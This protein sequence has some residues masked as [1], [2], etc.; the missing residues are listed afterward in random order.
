MGTGDVELIIQKHGFSR[1]MQ[2]TL[3][4][5]RFRISTIRTR[6]CYSLTSNNKSIGII[7]IRGNKMYSP[8][9]F[10][11]KIVTLMTLFVSVFIASRI[12]IQKHGWLIF[13]NIMITDSTNSCR[14]EMVIQ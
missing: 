12:P 13:H 11:L 4:D 10:P 8:L 14:L 6:N 9:Y 5:S 3:H 1:L 2:Q 7:G